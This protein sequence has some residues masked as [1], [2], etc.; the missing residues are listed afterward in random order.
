MREGE[1]VR[2]EEGV[3]EGEKAPLNGMTVL[4]AFL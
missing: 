2:S 4:R 3:R 1:Q